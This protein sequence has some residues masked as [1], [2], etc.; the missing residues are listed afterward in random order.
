MALII[1]LSVF[2]GLEEMVNKIFN[3]FDPDLSITAAEGKVFTPDST[4]LLRLSEIN[5][6]SA[7]SL[8]L[9]DNAALRYGDRQYIASIKGIDD[10]YR[11]VTNLDSS[12][13]EGEFRLKTATDQPRAVIGLGV[14]KYLGVNVDLINPSHYIC[15]PKNRRMLIVIPKCPD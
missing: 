1:I 14:A 8:T 6:I 7:Y 10:N 4:A 13:Y 12:M 15:S 2:N 11:D 9:E 3:T 5:G